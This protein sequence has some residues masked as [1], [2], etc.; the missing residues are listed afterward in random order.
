MSENVGPTESKLMTPG[1][2]IATFVVFALIAFGG[3]VVFSGRAGGTARIALPGS[4]SSVSARIPSDY[5]IPTLDGRQLRLSDYRG[6]VVVVDFWAIWCPPCR[7]EIPQLTRL[8]E[9]NRAKGV[10]VVGLHI[11]DRGRS[12]PEA[13]RAF[14]DQ[15]GLGYTVGFAT[16]EVFVDYLGEDETA[17]PQTLV[18]DRTGKL[19][20]HL[21]GY[22]DS[23]AGRLDAAVNRAIAA[24]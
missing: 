5:E 18:F 15:H 13:I 17:I 3:Y 12:S 24:R 16:D 7:K 23:D 10:E 9:A 20:E 14:V 11:D 21:I 6:K 19:V 2:V 22:G 4:D 1:R 8:A